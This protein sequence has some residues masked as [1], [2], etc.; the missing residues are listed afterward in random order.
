MTDTL[1]PIT[2]SPDDPAGD[3]PWG[4]WLTG[5]LTSIT[6][7]IDRP[8]RLVVAIYARF[9]VNHG[10]DSD[11]TKTQLRRGRQEAAR[12][13]P[14]A[15]I[16]EYADDG[17]KGETEDRPD[18]QRLLADIRAGLVHV[19]LAKNQSRI[20]RHP[21][22]WESFGDT[23][24]AHGITHLH[25]W[26]E[27]EIKLGD[28]AGE[29]KSTVN[30]N[31]NVQ[32]RRNVMD[33]LALYAGD[34][35]PPG[36]GC[37]GYRSAKLKKTDA[38]GR[39]V[40]TLV[41]IPKVATAIRYA[42]AMVIEGY[43]MTD[44]AAWL[45]D[46]QV[47]TTRKGKG[48]RASNVRRL[49]RSPTLAGIRVH[50]PEA[51][52]EELRS[53]GIHYFTLAVAKEHG[54]VYRGNWQAILDA[55]TFLAVQR[56]LD[57]PGYVTTSDGRQVRRGV[58]RGRNA[59][60]LLSGLAQCGRC[61]RGL[62]GT[63]RQAG[64]P[65]YICHQ[66]NGGCNGIGVMQ[67]DADAEVRTKFL[68]LLQSAGYRRHLAKGDPYAERRAGLTKEIARLDREAE[69]DED[70]FHAKR[71]SR[72]TAN[73]RAARNE[74]ARADAVVELDGLPPSFNQID[75]DEMLASWDHVGQAEQRQMLRLALD[76][77]EVHPGYPGAFD[78]DRIQLHRRRRP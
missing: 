74:R 71:I 3:D 1:D 61:G 28:L 60:Y 59:K 15:E 55:E 76:R 6:H 47:P 51:K 34:G 32:N 16:R 14:G 36:G 54:A 25:T 57:Q 21:R 62:T 33:H 4:R 29:I 35:R 44:V 52:R 50:I 13:W 23:C 56:I 26:L 7:A 31:Y 20:E 58:A 48:W 68:A 17:C 64:A 37:T 42:A 5:P 19:V 46:E 65:V 40:P 45:D 77:I 78:P 41:P 11:S 9:S 67:A 43:P 22:I 49:L 38:K 75:P 30:R 10:E 18:Y 2:A 69:A 24:L 72:A 8:T 73:R 63:K 27:G 53:T 66:G 12:G 70:D 39:P